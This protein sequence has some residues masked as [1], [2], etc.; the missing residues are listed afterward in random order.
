MAPASRTCCWNPDQ[1]WR[2]YVRN[3]TTSPDGSTEDEWYE[4]TF[5]S[6]DGLSAATHSGT[7]SYETRDGGGTLTSSGTS[8]Y[9][10]TIDVSTFIYSVTS[11]LDP[12]YLSATSMVVGAHTTSG[13]ATSNC[14]GY[15][16]YFSADSRSGGFG[17]LEEVWIEIEM[18]D[19]QPCCSYGESALSYPP[20]SREY[21]ELGGLL[22]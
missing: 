18:V 21:Y 3:K 9:G 6:G 20:P 13:S 10:G 1:Q 17:V 11:S 2:L 7:Y 16:G 5:T 4:G 19:P 15:T 22:P 12:G 8:A 14:S